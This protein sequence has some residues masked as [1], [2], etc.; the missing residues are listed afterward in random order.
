MR[1]RGIA[2]SPGRDLLVRRGLPGAP[3]PNAAFVWWGGAGDVLS[4]LCSFL[5]RLAA[6]EPRCEPAPGAGVVGPVGIRL[7]WLL[8]FGPR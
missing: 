8:S 7:G 4:V 6:S 5:P 1:S 2:P 3:Q